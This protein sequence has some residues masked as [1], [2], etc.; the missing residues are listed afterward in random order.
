MKNKKSKIVVPALALILLSTAASISGSVAWFT[1]A[2]TAVVKAGEFAVVRTGDDLDVSFESV[3]GTRVHDPDALTPDGIPADT[4]QVKEGYA[5]TDASFDHTKIN[6]DGPYVVKPTV[7]RDNVLDVQGIDDD[8]ANQAAWET[9]LNRGTGVYSAAIW[10]MTF[11]IDFSESS[12]DD[13][14]LF[15]DLSSSDTYMHEKVVVKDGQPIPDGLHTDPKCTS[16]PT[17]S[18]G[19]ASGD[20]TFYKATPDA[21]GKGFRIA[22][23]PTA[24]GGTGTGISKGYAKVWAENEGT[25]AGEGNY[26]DNSIVYDANASGNALQQKAT[27]YGKTLSYD[28]QDTEVVGQKYVAVTSGLAGSYMAAADTALNVPADNS[29]TDA[30]AL[31]TDK[32][33]L[34]FF[35]ADGGKKVTL[36]YTC[37]AWFEGS[38][39]YV[40]SEQP[41]ETMVVS[42]QFGVSNLGIH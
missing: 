12:T 22:F 20:Q 38:N 4:V 19:N 28:A 26:I 34:G 6:G 14:G 13:V 41:L 7:S 21:T 5:L 42:M 16:A 31:S 30:T 32:N 11:A 15:L 25:T 37:V 9:A 18:A 24:I 3:A 33:Y 2:R 40:V 23:I 1:A 39:P 8:I 10:K 35:K 27:A 36:T 17:S 29:R